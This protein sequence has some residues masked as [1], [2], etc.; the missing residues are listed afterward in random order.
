VSLLKK[1]VLDAN[2]IIDWNVTEVELEGGF[3]VR[4][5]FILDQKINQL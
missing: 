2:H 5:V 4:P 1:Y 3:Q